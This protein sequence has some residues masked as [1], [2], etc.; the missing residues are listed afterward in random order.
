V[1]GAIL[2][3]K[4]ISTGTIGRATTAARG[5]GR[6]YKE[7]QDVARAQE[8]AAAVKQQAEE[9]DARMRE[10]VAELEARLDPAAEQLETIS[11][12]PKKTDIDV[13]PV[14]LIW[15][16]YWEAAGAQPQRAWA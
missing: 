6:S 14:S 13:R 9:L 11:V 12:R 4:T 2:G 8:T 16:P 3:R 10:E 1:L 15:A 5:V 7:S